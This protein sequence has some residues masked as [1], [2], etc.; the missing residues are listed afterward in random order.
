MQIDPND[1]IYSTAT[2]LSG[3]W[4]AWENFATVGT[5]TYSSQTADVVSINGVVMYMGDRWVSTNLMTSTYVWLPVSG[6]L[7]DLFYAILV[8]ELTLKYRS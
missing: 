1:N 2:S 4:S 7:R 6:Y 5:N 8:N 3:P